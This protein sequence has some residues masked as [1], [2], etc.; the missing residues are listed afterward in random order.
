MHDRHAILAFLAGAA[1]SAL[2]TLLATIYAHA[3]GQAD[4]T[5]MGLLLGGLSSL[6]IGSV[7]LAAQLSDAYLNP[8]RRRR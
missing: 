4:T 6:A 8:Q 1:A 7:M 2:L 5:L 3:T